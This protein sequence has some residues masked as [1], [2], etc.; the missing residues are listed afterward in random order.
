MDE[1]MK[2]ILS[3]VCAIILL[4]SSGCIIYHGRH[5]DVVEPAAPVV[6]PVPVPAPDH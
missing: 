4:S 5:K 1:I 3:I 6:V 2:T